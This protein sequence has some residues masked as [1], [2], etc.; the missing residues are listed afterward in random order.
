VSF[1][2]SKRGVLTLGVVLLLALFLLRPGANRLRT[3]I[4]NSITLALGRPVDVAA[5]NLRLLPQPGFDLENFVIH[6]DPAFSAEP[7]LRAQQVTASLRMTSLLRGRLEIAR[8]NL[9]EPSLNLVRNAEGHWNLENLIER[10]AKITVAPTSKTKT[11]RRPGFPYIEADRGRINFKFGA[12]KKPYALTEADFALWQ[13]SENAWAMRLKTQPVRTDFNLTDTGLVTL[14]GSWQR[15][16]TLRETPLQFILQWDRAQLGQVTKLAYGNDKGWRGG[17]KISATIAGTPANL[18]I[19]AATSVQDFRRYDIL[20]GGDLRLAAQCSGR[21]SSPDQT[22]SEIACSAP[23]GNG[24]IAVNGSINSLLST[25][26][27]DL[28]LTAQ[29]LPIQ[30]LIGFARHAKQGLPD[31]LIATGRM[32]G[33]VRLRHAAHALAS[34]V[35]LEGSGETS[36][37]E[38]GSKLTKTQLVLGRVPFAVSAATNPKRHATSREAVSFPS[39]VHLE[40]GPFELTLGRP[41]PTMVRGWAS[42]SGYSFTVQGDA[43]VQHLLQLARTVGIRVPQPAADGLAKV[44]LQIAGDWSGFVAPRAMGKA[45][46]HS[47]RAEVRGLNAPVEIAS[48][49]LVLTPDKINVQNLTASI[50]DSSWHGSLTLPRQCAAPTICPVRFDL[51]ADEIATDRLN[52]L[53]NPHVRKQPWYRFLSSPATGVPYLLTVHAAGKLTANRVLIRKVAG[54]RVSANVELDKG[55]LRLSDL[56]GDV[57]GS[58]HIGEWEA[59]FTAKPPQYSGSG[60][61]ERIALNQLS[62]SMNDDWITGS[63]TAT[64][65]VQASGLDATEL[66]TSATSTLKVDA[67]DGLLRHVALAEGSGPLQMRRM[68]AQLFLH[69]G[70]FEIQEGKLETPAGIYRVSGTASLTRILNLKLT[71]ERAPGFNITGTLTEPHVSPILTPETRAALKP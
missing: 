58:K 53:V 38:L 52:Q 36:G 21:Y 51:H 24:T 10:A 3:R 25:R 66:F 44:D 57:L 47:I 37:F 39:E 30:S 20:G 27:Y 8:L 14:S 60:T 35:A 9:T 67:R 23:V 55:K 1:W 50:A 40:V 41:T 32:D 69:D 45:Q 28:A 68:A 34:D 43:Q 31:D 63:A 33:N 62:E 46:L 22:L 6:D 26:D 71:Q 18:T 2:R 59:D 17:L 64:Y 13:D 61:L 15:A 7:M 54:S 19:A 65:R 16:P 11:E 42:L 48:A 29:D 12:E 5:V 56:R 70:E 4:V 49:N